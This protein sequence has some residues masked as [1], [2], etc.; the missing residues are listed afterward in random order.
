MERPDRFDRLNVLNGLN[1]Y[2][3]VSDRGFRCNRIG[4]KNKATKEARPQIYL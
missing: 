2:R 1:Y 3:F 4:E